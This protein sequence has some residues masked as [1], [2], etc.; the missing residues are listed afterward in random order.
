MEQIDPF[1]QII[2]DIDK[3]P[4][5]DQVISESQIHSVDLHLHP[6]LLPTTHDLSLDF[7]SKRFNPVLLYTSRGDRDLGCI[8]FIKKSSPHKD[9]LDEY[10]TDPRV[11]RMVI[12][13]P[14]FKRFLEKWSITIEQTSPIT[15][16]DVLQAVYDSLRGPVTVQERQRLSDK[17]FRQ[18]S[19]A[20]FTRFDETKVL[21]PSRVDV[22]EGDHWF[23]GLMKVGRDSFEMIVKN[24]P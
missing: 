22:L 9:V 13:C 8:P 14:N 4:F 15:I 12:R 7:L 20:Y 24:S 23:G 3:D 19:E 10:A 5:L 16:R 18:M 2:E 21:G 17:R 11:A 1:Y 6:L